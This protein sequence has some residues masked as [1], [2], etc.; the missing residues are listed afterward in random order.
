MEYCPR[1]SL[2][3]YL[4]NNK[5]FDEQSCRKY[6]AQVIL[7]LEILHKNNLVHRVCIH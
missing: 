7:G 6:L 2:D 1:G 3:V 4:K 5:G